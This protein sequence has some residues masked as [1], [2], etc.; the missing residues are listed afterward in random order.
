MSELASGGL[1]RGS[2]RAALAVVLLASA[3]VLATCLLGSFRL[4]F[5]DEGALLAR[6]NGARVLLGAGAGAALALAGALRQAL[7]RERALFELELLA[8]SAGAAGG[9]VALARGLGGAAALAVFALGAVVGAGL[10]FGA[11]RALDRPRRWTNL[12]AAGLLVALVAAAAL[13]GTYAGERRDAIAPMVAWLVGDLSRATAT[14]STLVLL[15]AVGLAAAAWRALGAG[16]AGARAQAPAWLALGL[17]IGAAGPLVFV[18]RFVPR[19]LRALA[20]RASARALAAASLP[21]G[22]AAV[23]AIDAVP[24]GLVGGYALSWNVAAGLLALP[25][26]LGWNRARLR[27]LAGRAPLAFEIGELALIG[28][29]TL[30]AAALASVLTRVVRVLT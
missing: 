19:T 5:G 8:L 11:A 6:A 28:A 25:V 29:L 2:D 22:A 23:C 17:G 9:G 3:A 14:G 30:A 15:A 18:G 24:R 7:R 13:A 20:P 26:F 12:A 27:R 10:A 16:A 21:A 1:A 4:G